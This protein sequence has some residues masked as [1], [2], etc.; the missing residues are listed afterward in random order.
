MEDGRSESPLKGNQYWEKQG[1][2]N[3]FLFYSRPFYSKQLKNKFDSL[4]YDSNSL[5]KKC[6]FF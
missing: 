6:F 5:T 1:E 3:V 2:E 4:L